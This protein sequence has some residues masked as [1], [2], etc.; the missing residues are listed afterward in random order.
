MVNMAACYCG[1]LG[2]KS[3]QG[4]IWA[5]TCQ[6]TGVQ[7]STWKAAHRGPLRIVN[8]D[9][10]N[11]LVLRVDNRQTKVVLNIGTQKS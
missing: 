10:Y 6:G 7:S 11:Q 9:V 8:C 4:R 2:L 5:P 3:Q 1:G